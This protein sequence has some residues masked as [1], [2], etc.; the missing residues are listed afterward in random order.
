MR[1]HP[2]RPNC[3]GHLAPPSRIRITHTHTHT[4]TPCVRVH[5]AGI[6]A[7]EPVPPAATLPPAATWQAAHYLLLKGYCWRHMPPPESFAV[8][9]KRL[10]TRGVASGSSSALARLTLGQS[11]S[12]S[13]CATTCALSQRLRVSW[14]GKGGPARTTQSLCGRALARYR[15][16][17][18]PIMRARQCSGEAPG[19]RKRCRRRLRTPPW[20]AGGPPARSRQRCQQSG[21]AWG[22]PTRRAG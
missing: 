8:R 17:R 9:E 15:W 7:G 12:N 18:L 11:F 2:A 21:S 13:K 19:R 3:R 16:R 10:T 20:S 1:R 6:A 4:H 5:G 14:M 22:S